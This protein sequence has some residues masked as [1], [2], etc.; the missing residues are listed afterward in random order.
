MHRSVIE[1]T[2]E[3]FLKIVQDN[4]MGDAG[5]TVIARPLT[6]EEAIG[7]PERRDFPIIEGKER[8][9]EAAVFESKGHAYTDSPKQYAGTVKDVYELPM[10][11]N[12]NRAVYLATMNAVL[13]H[14][15]ISHGTVHCRDEEPEQ[16]AKEMAEYI[17]KEYGKVKVGLIGLNPAIAE[18]L[19]H[20]GGAENVR[21]T[22]L[23]RDNIRSYKF[24][25]EVWDGRGDTEDLVRDSDLIVITGTTMVNG[26][27]DRILEYI[28]KYNKNYFVYGVTCA[29]ICSLTGIN[30][31]CPYGHDN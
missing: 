16:C 3:K 13:R 5:V 25:V 9:I 10:T 30:R 27:F 21:I 26:T 14:L 7:N 17:L 1:S 29:G 22:D 19:V 23:N 28:E 8:V 6:P 2:R 18:M 15:E 11:T 12:Q 24:G 31:V 4:N 20:A